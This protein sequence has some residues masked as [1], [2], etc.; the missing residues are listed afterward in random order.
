[1]ARA[2]P[3][4]PRPYATS[5]AAGS[6]HLCSITTQVQGVGS[7]ESEDEPDPTGAMLAFCRPATPPGDRAGLHA[8]ATNHS[9]APGQQPVAGSKARCPTAWPVTG[10]LRPA[11]TDCA[12]SGTL[13]SLA[14]SPGA[15]AG[16]AERPELTWAVRGR[17]Q[18]SANWSLSWR[19]VGNS[20]GSSSWSSTSYI[21]CFTCRSISLIVYS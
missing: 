4:Q 18:W 7:Q 13:R 1:M 15:T 5:L 21:I 11:L 10:R 20:P 16:G 3:A 12:Q 6:M 9:Q 17:F 8:W 14:T 19:R 2:A